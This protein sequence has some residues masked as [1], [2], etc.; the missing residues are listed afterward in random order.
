MDEVQIVLLTLL[1]L[2]GGAWL[3]NQLRIIR[4]RKRIKKTIEE[5]N[6]LRI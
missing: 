6:K 4:L 2:I 3:I 5:Y 1:V